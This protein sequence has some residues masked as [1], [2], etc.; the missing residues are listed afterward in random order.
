MSVKTVKLNEAIQIVKKELNITNVLINIFENDLF[1]KDHLEKYNKHWLDNTEGNLDK[2]NKELRNKKW[3]SVV[4]LCHHTKNTDEKINVQTNEYRCF[5]CGYTWDIIQL[6]L[7]LVKGVSPKLFATKTKG[8]YGKEFVET[9]KEL[10]EQLGYRVEN[11]KRILTKAER[12]EIRKFEILRKSVEIYHQIF[13]NNKTAKNF[14]FETRGFKY[15]FKSEQEG[16]N[17]VKKYKIGYASK[18]F[19]SDLLINELKNQY[20]TQ[21]LIDSGVVSYFEKNNRKVF[22]DFHSESLIVPYISGRKV[23]NIYGRMV[24]SNPK[25]DAKHLRLGGEVSEPLYFDE[26]FKHRDILV[27][28][29]ELDVL[30]L[31]ALEFHNTIGT[32]G[33]NGLKDEFIKKLKEVRQ[34]SKGEFCKRI[35]LGYDGDDAGFKAIE[36]DG[37]RLL[38]EGFEVFV[39]VFPKDS[40][41]NKILCDYKEN[42]KEKLQEIINNAIH[43]FTFK[44]LR[45]LAKYKDEDEFLA[46][47]KVKSTLN[48]FK[49]DNNQLYLVAKQVGNILQIP[50]EVIWESWKSENINEEKLFE[51]DIVFITDNIRNFYR[52]EISFPEETILLKSF[53][54]YLKKNI[55]AKVIL[56]DSEMNYDIK[57]EIKEVFS[58]YII[59]ID[60]FKKLYQ[61]NRKQISDFIGNCVKPLWL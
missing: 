1:D 37:E 58:G 27:F 52:S 30:T 32:F 40:D 3:I 26:A 61:Y 14:F 31:K 6:Y 20:T 43:Y 12:D 10:A 57:K 51:K 56:I 47:A 55:K 35:I 23:E 24:V 36:R 53:Y 18:R 41:A 46:Y 38:K 4:G 15:A 25:F 54:D 17:F 29:G 48:R 21:E 5:R 9:V 44:S 34:K 50:E 60:F 42:A 13:L 7:F 22:R 2:L 33:T 8:V 39:L 28:E 11:K 59:E 45:E 49:L 19:P 16:M